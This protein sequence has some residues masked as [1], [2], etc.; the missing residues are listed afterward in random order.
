MPNY[1][2]NINLDANTL[3]ALHVGNYQ[4]QVYKGAKSDTNGVPVVWFTLSEFT[5]NLSIKWTTKYGGYFSKITPEPNATVD[6]STY[7]DMDL[8]NVYTLNEDGA[9]ILGSGSTS[10]AYSFESQMPDQWTC[11]LTALA[12]GQPSPICA[13]PQFGSTENIIEPYEKIL[14]LFTKAQVDTGSV[15]ET[16]VSKS[17]SM[18]LSPSNPNLKV[19]FD[20]NTTW[21]NTDGSPYVKINPANFE[22]APELIIPRA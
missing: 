7:S 4:M 6:M 17:A 21:Q 9:G 18:T 3:H 8:G 11:G 20:I 19:S 13:F 12:N 16:A 10:T 15:V 2:V 5:S 14:V 1:Q 22:L